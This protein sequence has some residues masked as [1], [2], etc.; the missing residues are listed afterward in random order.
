MTNGH[1]KLFQCETTVISARV[2]RIGRLAG[3]TT[4]AGR[5]WCCA[6]QR[7]ALIRSA[8]CPEVLAQQEDRVRRAEHERQHQR[9]ERVAQTGLGQHQVQR[10][11]RDGGRHHQR[12]D[13]HPEQG[14][15]AGNSSRANA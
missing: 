5:G 9:P 14:V 15:A 1:R 12:R 13:V 3:S 10:D 4:C 11:H 2:T 6:V 8:G 7:A